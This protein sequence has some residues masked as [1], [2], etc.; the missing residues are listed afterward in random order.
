MQ[1]VSRII[2]L[3]RDLYDGHPWLD[4]TLLTTLQ[5]ITPAEA[6]AR[7]SPGFNSIWEIVNHLVQWRLNV[8]ERVRGNV[9][10]TPG[11]N[12]F[13]PVKDI[14]SDSWINTLKDLEDSQM[15]WL[16]FLEGLGESDLKKVYPNN[17]MTYYEHIHGILQ[18]DAYHL[19]QISLLAKKK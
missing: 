7:I 16:S 12:Y 1:E 13:E 5:K 9:I 8:L 6:A 4:V 3:F 19:G 11:D 18:H 14:S 17:N 15:Q 2:K 10:I